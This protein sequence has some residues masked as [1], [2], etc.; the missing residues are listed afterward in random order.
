MNYYTVKLA[1][2]SKDGHYVIMSDHFDLWALP[3]RP[4]DA[5]KP[6]RHTLDVRERRFSYTWLDLEGKMRWLR[7]PV[8]PVP[9]DATSWT[10]LATPLYLNTTAQDRLREEEG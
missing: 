5:A 7:K 8:R 9:D 2:W 1:G 6:I 4:D 10:D 3:R